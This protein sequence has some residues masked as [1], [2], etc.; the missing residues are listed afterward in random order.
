MINRKSEE[1]GV[2]ER[3]SRH[4]FVL[5]LPSTMFYPEGVLALRSSTS[6]P[7][8]ALSLSVRYET[9]LEQID[10]LAPVPV[11]AWL[12][13]EWHRNLLQITTRGGVVGGGFNPSDCRP[14]SV[15]KPPS[16]CHNVR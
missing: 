1:L 10:R 11:S 5:F 16:A 13:A 7:V 3:A 12:A 2:G 9:V 14:G 8:V 4:L 15:T 6:R